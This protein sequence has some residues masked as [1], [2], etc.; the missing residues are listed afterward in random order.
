MAATET[1]PTDALPPPA[2]EKTPV[3]PETPPPVR[4]GPDDIGIRDLLEA[5]VH[6][7]HQTK[8]WNPKM[9]RYIFDKRNGIHVIDLAKSMAM[10]KEALSFLRDVTLS[11][12]KVLLVGTKKQAQQIIRETAELCGQP[13]V[14]TRWLGG[15]M[16]NSDT[17]RR[18][19]R[20]L[21]TLEAIEK[22]DDFAS[23]HKKEASRTRHEL[24]KLRH[25]LSGIAD[26]IDTPGA[27][28]VVDV[29]RESIAIKEA[30]KLNIP[31]VAMVDTN[32]D[33]DPI[34][35]VIPGNDDA[36]RAVEL[37]VGAMGRVMEQARDEYA[38]IAA[39]LARKKEEDAKKA[40]EAKKAA[41]EAK[42]AAQ[43]AAKADAKKK[44]DDAAAKR[45]GADKT[46][47][48]G[49]GPAAKAPAS[50]R[51]PR[52][53]ATANK[54]PDASKEKDGAAKKPVKT[55]KPAAAKTKTKDAAKTASKPGSETKA[56]KTQG[57]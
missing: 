51:K 20:R 43:D 42:K 3:I 17:I 11:G 24:G 28:F 15:A 54:T 23:M 31:V 33:P 39:E 47:K 14:I 46:K 53:D 12:K 55:D 56:A 44:T 7:G 19:V 37:I 9:K 5:G 4:K 52:P 8:R 16:T 38:K 18:S 32:C 30:R 34:D 45:V 13:Y 35:Y 48:D 6:F 25:N 10:L 21:K 50:D 22:K 29:N 26:M 1:V 41:Q 40:A 49:P 27:V 57:D 36:I 2:P